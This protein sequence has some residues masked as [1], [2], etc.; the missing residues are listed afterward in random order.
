MTDRGITASPQTYARIGGV[1]G[2]TIVAAGI[3]AEGVVRGGAIVSGDAA[4]TAGNIMASEQLWRVGFAGELLM[5]CADIAFAL[6]LY[7][8]LKPVNRNLA[9][10]AAFFRLAMAA[11]SGVN[12]MNHFT[13]LLVLGGADYLTVFQPDQLHALA[14]L[15]LKTHAFAYHIAL[16]FF[17]F[18]L[19]LLGWL[20]MASGY[21]PKIIGVMLVIAAFCYL[22]NS[23]ANILDLEFASNLFPWILLPSLIAEMSLTLWLLVMGV[24]MAKW[25]ARQ[26]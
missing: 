2:L 10:L 25:K 18:H 14:Y 21:L 6:V 8:I 5:L 9:L 26:A 13:P 22:T 12:A 20:V 11:I 24:N 17:G 3:F 19:I 1:L 4:A 7:V 16:V 23:F 15:A